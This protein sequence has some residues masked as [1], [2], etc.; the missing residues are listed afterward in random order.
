MRERITSATGAAWAFCIYLGLAAVVALYQGRQRW[1]FA[2]DWEFLQK[3]QADSFSDLM[4]PYNDHW[5]AMPLVAYRSLYALFG[6][7]SYR[8]YQVAA[9]VTHLA[10][11]VLVR[12]VMRRSGVGPWAAT[13]A[14]SILVLLGPGGENILAAFQISF[15]L[16]VALALGQFLLADGPQSGVMRRLAAVGLGI[17]A[18]M[19]AAVAIPVVAAT[20]AA[21]WVRHGWRRAA[22]QVAPVAGLYGFWYVSTS[23]D[24]TGTEFPALAELL[25]WI[26]DAASATVGAI[27]ASTIVG[28]VLVLVL[29][30]GT[31]LALLDTER[32]EGRESEAGQA[33]WRDR[34]RTVAMPLALLGSALGV[35]LLTW[36]GRGASGVADAAASRYL[37]V[38]VALVLPALAVALGAILRRW[39]RAG[40]FLVVMLL[41]PIVGNA[42][43]GEIDDAA[44]PGAFY[45]DQQRVHR[46]VIRIDEF[47]RARP[48]VTPVVPLFDDL[49][50][51]VGFL[52]QAESSGKL[53]PTHGPMSDKQVLEYR[54]RLGLMQQGGVQP[55]GCTPAVPSKPRF[56][57]V[58]ERYWFTGPIIVGAAD[59]P[60]L[61]FANV[62]FYPAQGNILE[63]VAPDLSLRVTLN[64]LGELL[65]CPAT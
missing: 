44:F 8:P 11:A 63:V 5:V 65:S 24:R 51:T 22:E 56:H 49:S 57:D 46:S 47:D 6:F 62:S 61:V 37:Y 18:V 64:G 1:F 54:L 38:Y 21:L 13:M 7:T 19:S 4:T 36:L 20:G 23:S 2:D 35:A 32:T 14:A 12:L 58:G 55:D 34:L 31:G 30:I 28:P 33:S 3:R 45:A 40:A 15:T 26:G 50:P 16:A 53:D 25:E 52:Q 27:G 41:V 42:I 9:L 29:L 60:P 10:V 17:G 43:S 48:D 39:E 59:G